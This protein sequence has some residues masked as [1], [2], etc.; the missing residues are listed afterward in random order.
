EVKEIYY[1][2]KSEKGKDLVAEPLKIYRGA[3]AFEKLRQK[4][5]HMQKTPEVFLFTYGNLAMRKARAGFSQNFFAC[6]GFKV[7]DN[8]GFETIQQGIEAFRKSTAE[9][10]VICSSD[11]EYEQIAP[12]IYKSLKDDKIIVV[13]GYPKN[14][15][16]RLKDEG[17]EYFIHVKSNALQELNHFTNLILK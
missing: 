17:I 6:A 7:I 9:I 12:E 13:A 10:V 16:E 5:E 2:P 8:L 1:F 14:C 4:V 15:V 11:D 3:Q